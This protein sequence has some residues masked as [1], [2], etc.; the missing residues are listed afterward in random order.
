VKNKVRKI[1]AAGLNLE[2][3]EVKPDPA[4][5]PKYLIAWKRD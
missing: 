1:A 2:G 4:D 5:L 3:T